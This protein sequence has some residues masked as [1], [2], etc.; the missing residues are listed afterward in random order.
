MIDKVL[1]YFLFKP[2]P[3]KDIAYNYYI[4]YDIWYRTVYNCKKDLI[5]KI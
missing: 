5:I 2:K 4:F 1:E 3:P